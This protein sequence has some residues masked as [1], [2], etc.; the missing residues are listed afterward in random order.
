LIQLIDLK[1]C[2]TG[3]DA[4][5]CSLV[6]P[7]WYPW[8]LGVEVRFALDEVTKA[9]GEDDFGL[10]QPTIHRPKHTGLV[11]EMVEGMGCCEVGGFPL[12]GG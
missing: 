2:L 11:V 10:L 3:G 4:N 12:I 1:L 8:A 5:L 6:S 9:C 7:R